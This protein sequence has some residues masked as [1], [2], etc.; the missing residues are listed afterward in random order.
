MRMFDHVCAYTYIY[1]DVSAQVFLK[2]SSV[3]ELVIYAY[4]CVLVSVS[5][6]AQ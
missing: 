2:V 3:M 4:V 5:L 1:S 6:N